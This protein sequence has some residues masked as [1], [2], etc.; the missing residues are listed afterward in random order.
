MPLYEMLKQHKANSHYCHRFCSMAGAESAP[1]APSPVLPDRVVQDD[2][3]GKH[4][5]WPEDTY[6]QRRD[7]SFTKSA[8][9][10]RFFSPPA[11][12]PAQHLRAECG[13]RMRQAGTCFPRHTPISRQGW[14]HRDARLA[15]TDSDNLSGPADCHNA[16]P[17]H[18]VTRRQHWQSKSNPRH[19]AG[20]LFSCA[21]CTGSR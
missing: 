4:V 19:V 20:M 5:S 6:Q 12:L 8:S 21:I 7:A 1:R 9:E 13:G 11:P 3:Q 17:W 2:F 14:T 16:G 15:S 18:L 10:P